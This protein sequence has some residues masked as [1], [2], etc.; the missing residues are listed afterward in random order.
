MGS[1]IIYYLLPLLHRKCAMIAGTLAEV[2]YHK[3]YMYNYTCVC[4]EA[5]TDEILETMHSPF[6]G[7][8]L[9][10]AGVPFLLYPTALSPSATQPWWWKAL[11][12]G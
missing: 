11:G 4:V 8:L 10:A 5:I 7:V 6:P 1:H 9:S 12:P 2:M 3:L